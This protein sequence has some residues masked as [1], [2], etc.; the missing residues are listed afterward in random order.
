MY[1]N[2]V[3]NILLIG[4]LKLKKVQIFFYLFPFKHIPNS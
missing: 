1:F 2:I 3:I 4:K